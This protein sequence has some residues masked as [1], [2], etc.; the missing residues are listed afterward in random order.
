MREKE[1]KAAK[2]E[3]MKKANMAD[4]SGKDA[5]GGEEMKPLDTSPEHD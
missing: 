1:A 4:D 3:L 5:I 2:L